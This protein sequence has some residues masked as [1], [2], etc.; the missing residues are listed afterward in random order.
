MDALLGFSAF[1][2][3]YHNPSDREMSCA[4]HSYMLRALKGHAQ[5]LRGGVDE[6][7]AETVFATSTFVSFHAA[8]SQRLSTES[9]AKSP[10][11][12]W[13][14]SYQGIKAI[15]EVGWKWIQKSSI[16]PLLQ[17]RIKYLQNPITSQQQRLQLGVKELPF[18]FLLEGIFLEEHDTATLEAYEATVAHLNTVGLKNPIVSHVLLFPAAVCRRFVEMVEA[19]DPRTLAIVGYFFM[20]LKKAEKMWQVWWLRSTID[21]EF[22]ILMELLPSKWWPKMEW[23]VSVFQGHSDKVFGGF[24]VQHI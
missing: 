15:L 5:D 14:R 17:E 10:P 20:L 8:M 4:S 6:K 3:L 7:N 11:I 19:Q 23:A 22:K 12:H 2:L 16:E 21:D 13:F 1:H 9:Q 24:S 18:D